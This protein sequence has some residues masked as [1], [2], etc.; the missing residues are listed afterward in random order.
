MM[1]C[2]SGYILG[3]RSSGTED[4]ER[5]AARRNLRC[6]RSHDRLRSGCEERVET[7]IVGR[8]VW[9][10]RDRYLRGDPATRTRGAKR[11]DPSDVICGGGAKHE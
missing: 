11:S 6:V 4:T 10:P 2:V 5:D 9:V 1:R 7:R 3:A 8:F